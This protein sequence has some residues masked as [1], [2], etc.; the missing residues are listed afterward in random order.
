MAKMSRRV[1]G[2]AGLGAHAPSS[3]TGGGPV[4]LGGGWQKLGQD[5][6][7][8]GSRLDVRTEMQPAVTQS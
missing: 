7:E 6:R 3:K 2:S 8:V 1:H 4:E 5:V